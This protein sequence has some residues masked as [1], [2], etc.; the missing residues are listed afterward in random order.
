MPPSQFLAL[1]IPCFPG[2]LPLLSCFPVFILFPWFL[3]SIL[4]SFQLF[5]VCFFNVDPARCQEHTHLSCDQT[6]P[7]PSVSRINEN[8]IEGV[9]VSQYYSNSDDTFS[10]FFTLRFTPQEGDIA[11]CAVTHKGLRQSQTRL[12]GERLVSYV[13]WVSESLVG[14]AAGLLGVATG[15]FFLI[16]G[17]QCN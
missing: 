4:Y 1:S 10:N 5:L 6:S 16:K 9:S 2:Y 11:S 3:I 8:M 14:L 13:G 7:I 15:T 12:L 17:N